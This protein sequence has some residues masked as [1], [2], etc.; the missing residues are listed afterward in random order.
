VGS[1]TEDLSKTP[2][3]GQYNAVEPNV[4]RQKQA[5]Y[6]LKGRSN[7]PGDSTNKPGPGAYSPEKV[8]INKPSIPK[9]TLGIRHSEYITPLLIDV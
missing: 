9:S 3:P 5:I 6:S 8:T 1:Y 2:G 4:I 7:I